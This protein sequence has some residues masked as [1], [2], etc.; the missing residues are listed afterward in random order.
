MQDDPA[1]AGAPR[2][3]VTTARSSTANRPG[4]ISSTSDRHFAAAAVGVR[5]VPSGPATTIAG[6]AR[7]PALRVRTA[8]RVAAA[9]AART[10]RECGPGRWSSS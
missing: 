1:T 10:R 2:A 5:G 4:A 6:S 9:R 8:T 7:S 3:P